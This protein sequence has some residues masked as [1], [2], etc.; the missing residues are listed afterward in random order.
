VSGRLPGTRLLALAERIVDQTTLER[1]VLPALAD[2]Q[3]ECAPPA[4]VAVRLRA[5]WGYLRLLTW[6]SLRSISIDAGR[7][8]PMVVRR[9]GVPFALLT[10]LLVWPPL[11]EQTHRMWSAGLLACVSAAVLLLPQVVALALPSAHL[12]G[13]ATSDRPATPI[14]RRR[15]HVGVIVASLGCVLL[16][17]VIANVVIPA[18]NQGYRV[19]LFGIMNNT[20]PDIRSVTVSKGLAEMNWSE[21]ND[22]IRNPATAR[23]GLNARIYRQIRLAICVAPLVFGLLALR[24]AGRW[25]SRLLSWSAPIVLLL[26]YWGL[27]VTGESLARTPGQFVS[28]IWLGNVM[29]FLAAVSPS[30]GIAR[31]ASAT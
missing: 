4:R 19:L 30:F 15:R 25:R 23:S 21:L 28:A 8:F 20:S 2:L 26:I 14:D 18:A 5:Y 6:L 16:M 1:V 9:T 10:G 29:F 13:L 3:H 22:Q 27:M 24:L 7:T 31:R 12:I 11:I 17:F